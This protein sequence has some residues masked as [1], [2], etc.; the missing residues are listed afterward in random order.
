[1]L[2]QIAATSCGIQALHTTGELVILNDFSTMFCCVASFSGFISA[3]VKAVWASLEDDNPMYTPR[4]W[5][6]SPIDK[7]TRKV[8]FF[9][10]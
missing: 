2:S 3:L 5:P 10:A 7:Y 8:C 9:S 4:A 6:V 1:M